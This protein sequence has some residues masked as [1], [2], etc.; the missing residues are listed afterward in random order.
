M[1]SIYMAVAIVLALKEWGVVG[2]A[3][4]VLGFWMLHLLAHR[5]S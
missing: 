1:T 3:M 2:A 4:M 5:T